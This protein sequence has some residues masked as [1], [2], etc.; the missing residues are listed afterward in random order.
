VAPEPL[1]PATGHGPGR[2]SFPRGMAD[3]VMA[4]GAAGATAGYFSRGAPLGVTA[5]WNEETALVRDGHYCFWF[6]AGTRPP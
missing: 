5:G 4:G 6:S 1:S 3:G 2:R